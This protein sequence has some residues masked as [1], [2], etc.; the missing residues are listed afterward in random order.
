MITVRYASSQ[1]R[2][3]NLKNFDREKSLCDMFNY[4]KFTGDTDK[5]LRVTTTEGEIL[6]LRTS[7]VDTC[8]FSEAEHVTGEVCFGTYKRKAEEDPIKKMSEKI[9][10]ASEKAKEARVQTFLETLRERG[11]QPDF[12]DPIFKQ[13]LDCVMKAEGQPWKMGAFANIYTNYKKSKR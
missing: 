4:F 5:K 9:V 8:K 7:E 13:T 1:E 10:Q 6:D 11:V 12:N 3:F 2:S